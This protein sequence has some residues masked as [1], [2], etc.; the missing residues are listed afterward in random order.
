MMQKIAIIALATIAPAAQ[1]AEPL[2]K[3]TRAEERAMALTPEEASLRMMV[4]GTDELDPTIWVSSEPF[5]KGSGDDKFFRAAIDKQSRAVVY[6]IYLRST[7]SRGP[8]RLSK[9]T[10]MVA[11]RLKSVQVERVDLDVSC[12]SL[13]L[14]FEDAIAE[15]PREDLEL[16]AKDTGPAWR[17]RLFGDTVQGIDAGFLRNETAGFLIAVDRVLARQAR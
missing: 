14:H 11:G 8:L 12:R 9:M 13:C 7:S 16:L 4:R 6:Q 1:A 17:A 3:P 5:L 10:Y 15:I 2:N